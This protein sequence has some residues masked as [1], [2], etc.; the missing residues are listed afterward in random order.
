MRNGP[1]SGRNLRQRRFILC[2]EATFYASGSI[3]TWKS[4][5]VEE[6]GKQTGNR[7]HDI[8]IRSQGGL[9]SR[10]RINRVFNRVIFAFN[11]ALIRLAERRNC[12]IDVK[13]E[14]STS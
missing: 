9:N 5:R 3:Y 14:K 12:F 8:G 11:N 6:S 13:I 1:R 10:V 4:E 2:R 7:W